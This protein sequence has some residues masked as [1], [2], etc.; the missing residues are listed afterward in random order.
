MEMS[1]QQHTTRCV[2]RR[3]TNCYLPEALVAMFSPALPVAGH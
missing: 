2:T 1:E 3:Q